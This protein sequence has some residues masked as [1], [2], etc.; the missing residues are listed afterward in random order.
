M[1]AAPHPIQP[2]VPISHSHLTLESTL[3]ALRLHHEQLESECLGKEIYE[4]FSHDPLLPGVILTEQ[5]K[6]VGMISRR[7]FMEQM[8][9]PYG[10]EL[11]LKR[12]LSVLYPF[13][14]AQLLIFSH[15]TPIVTAARESLQRPPE[16]LYEPVLVQLQPQV[17]G[18]VDVHE[19]LIAQSQIH[20]LARQMINE[21]NEAQMIQT[22]KMATLGR[23]I[24]SVAHEIL[25]PVNFVSGNLNYL[26]LYIKDL[27]KV[28]SAYEVELP[29]PSEQ[30]QHLKEEIGFSFLL[31]DLPRM[32]DS[33][34][35]GAERL[36]S[37]VGSLRNFSYM[38]ESRR[39]PANLHDCID[40]TLLILNSRIKQGI[41]I[42]KAY[43]DL[44]LVACY[45]GQIS[46]VF[47]NLISNAIDALEEVLRSQ[48]TVLAKQLATPSLALEPEEITI[49]RSWQPEIKITTGLIEATIADE[50]TTWVFVRIAD[51][52]PGIP[53]EIQARIFETFFTTKPVG[54]G[55]GLG[56]AI[57]HQIVTEKHQGK[58]NLRSEPGAGT[59]FEVL[60]PLIPV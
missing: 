25:N 2:D 50:V 53:P 47:M 24:A 20:E 30:T 19:L 42:N 14:N 23:I 31:E 27:L 54:K 46:Q 60:L 48:R 17:Y 8:S 29:N 26:S 33:V 11:F 58:L 49:D 37:V 15:N 43:S 28:I 57:S 6:F 21:Q 18:L 56:L 3:E 59:E 35:I 7:R 13:I 12:S 36:R 10:L 22:E 40:N 5:G 39:K 52:G 41:H 45:A 38:D 51:N 9:R 4:R 44:P 32:L 34:K 16:L 55:T 1:L